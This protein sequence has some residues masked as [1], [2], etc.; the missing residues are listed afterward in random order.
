[1]HNT[2]KTF[3]NLPNK[4]SYLY[5]LRQ[6]ARKSFTT[7]ELRKKLTEKEASEEAITYALKKCSPYINDE[8]IIRRNIEVEFEK[9]KG[10]YFIL[11]KVK[12]RCDFST[13]LL[14]QWIDEIAT[15]EKLIAIAE[16]LIAKR[17][18]DKQKAYRFLVSRG[19]PLDV[20]SRTLHVLDNVE[21]Q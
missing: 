11:M 14:K 7:F 20:I 1:M 16:K 4:E 18:K 15:E 5:C 13:N 19:F 9:G 2:R 21:M 17:Y 3:S 6:L 10:P 12:R 8:E